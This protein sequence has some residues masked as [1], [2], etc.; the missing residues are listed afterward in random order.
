MTKINLN[1]TSN[2]LREIYFGEGHHKYFFGPETKR[3]SWMLVIALVLYPVFLV[4]SIQ[5]ED[6]WLMIIG[7][8]YLGLVMYDFQRKTRPIIYWKKSVEAFL[9][10]VD[11]NTEH[12]LCYDEDSI[13]FYQGDSEV[14]MLWSGIKKA[15]INDSYI[16]LTAESNLLF[17]KNSM[18]ENEFQ[19]LKKV[20][21]KKVAVVVEK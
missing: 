18:T 19:L 1:Y 13:S 17:S 11:A 14:K 16:G 12:R 20:V 21:K 6:N 7:T 3:Q 8:I 10:R 15:S 2:D 9:A 5:L 4:Y